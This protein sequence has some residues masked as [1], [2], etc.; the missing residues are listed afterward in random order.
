[1][2]KQKLLQA[3][4]A[5]SILDCDKAKW[6]DA[7]S[8]AIEGG[9][10]TLHFDVMDG[11]F[12]PNLSFGASTIGSLRKSF[13]KTFFDCHFMVT[14]PE[15]HVGWLYES[16]AASKDGDNLLGFTFH[17]EVTSK[18]KG[19]TEK[20]IQMIKDKRMKVG[21]ALSPDTPVESVLPYAH[22]VDLVLVMTV[23]PGLGGQSFMPQV[24]PKVKTLREKFPELNIQVDGG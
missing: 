1:M 17:I 21:V 5:P 18:E 20:I 6:G 13:P 4:I 7:L 22:L 16:A 3:I 24:L 8:S 19:R 15:S 9:C 14:N 2:K 10:D 23:H 12:V 11:H